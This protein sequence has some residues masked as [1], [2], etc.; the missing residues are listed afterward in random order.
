M[1]KQVTKYNN[2]FDIIQYVETDSI[3]NIISEKHYDDFGRLIFI[4]DFD[5]NW[6]QSTYN[7]QNKL[8]M[9]KYKSGWLEWEFNEH[10]QKIYENNER[11]EWVKIE[12][13]DPIEWDSNVYYCIKK[14]SEWS[15]VSSIYDIFGNIIRR[16]VGDNKNTIFGDVSYSCRYDYEANSSLIPKITLYDNGLSAHSTIVKPFNYEI[17]KRYL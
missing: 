10:G 15:G 14:K 1:I 16:S 17:F 6:Q 12:Y 11:N 3:G 7:D 2:N 8:I 4:K 13:Y 9:V 5:G